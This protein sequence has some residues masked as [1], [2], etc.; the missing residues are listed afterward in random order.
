M[1]LKKVGLLRII[2]MEII[3]KELCFCMV[4]AVMPKL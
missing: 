4:Q 2:L 3:K 1:W